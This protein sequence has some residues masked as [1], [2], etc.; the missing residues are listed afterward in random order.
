MRPGINLDSVLYRDPGVTM[1]DV[2]DALEGGLDEEYAVR[3]IK[4]YLRTPEQKA[5][6]DRRDITIEDCLNGRTEP[7][8]AGF[9]LRTYRDWNA[10]LGRHHFG[11][12]PPAAP[13]QTPSL[14]DPTKTFDTHVEGL[15]QTMALPQQVPPLDD[16]LKAFDTHAKGLLR[17]MALLHNGH[18]RYYEMRFLDA[19]TPAIELWMR[20]SSDTTRMV[21][22]LKV[23]QMSDPPSNKQDSPKASNAPA[24]KLKHTPRPWFVDRNHAGKIMGI[25]PVNGRRHDLD[26]ICTID[27]NNHG[28]IEANANLIAA[29][30]DLLDCLIDLVDKLQSARWDYAITANAREAIASATAH[31]TPN[32]STG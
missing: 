18:D 19:R 15:L 13:Q 23:T 29:S 25:A 1:S 28:D 6:F 27:P 11:P 5:E 26:F 17:T 14:P 4:I 7:E 16:L 22:A 8:H 2:A 3:I 12:K 21:K 24:G 10:K 20:D 30:P 9:K 32:P 31:K